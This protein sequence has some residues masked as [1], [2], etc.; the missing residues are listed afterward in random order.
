MQQKTNLYSSIVTSSTE[1]GVKP[2]SAERGQ[3]Y[4]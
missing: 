4:H 2:N 3:C 1:C